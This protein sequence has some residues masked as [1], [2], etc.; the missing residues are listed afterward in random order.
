MQESEGIV[1]A[2]CMVSHDGKSISTRAFHINVEPVLIGRDESEDGFT[3]FVGAIQAYENAT[4]ISTEAATAAN[5][6]AEAAN[7]AASDLR[8]A[9]ANGDF[10][11]DDGIDGADGFSPVAN[12]TQTASG[13]TITITDANGTTTASIANGEKGDTGASVLILD[14]NGLHPQKLERDEVA[15]VE[16]AQS[17]EFLERIV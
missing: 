2:Q 7:Q 10:D 3:L 1:E 5:N 12:V 14:L 8:Q 11:G 4:G 9:A 15:K 6:A 17:Y 13:A 16:L